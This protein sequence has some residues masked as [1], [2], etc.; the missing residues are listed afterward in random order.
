M[1]PDR[2]AVS[3][4]LSARDARSRAIDRCPPIGS[5]DALSSAQRPVGETP[6]PTTVAGLPQC[7]H[8][9]RRAAPQATRRMVAPR[10]RAV[11]RPAQRL[12]NG[13]HGSG[14][15]CSVDPGPRGRFR[16]RWGVPPGPS[17]V[18]CDRLVLPTRSA[19]R[20]AVR[21]SRD[22]RR[23]DSGYGGGVACLLVLGDL[24]QRSDARRCSYGLSRCFRRAGRPLMATR[25]GQAGL[26]NER[27]GAALRY[28]RSAAVTGR[29]IARPRRTPT[30]RVGVVR[31][32]SFGGG[33]AAATLRVPRARGTILPARTDSPDRAHHGSDGAYLRAGSG[34]SR[35]W[36]QN[37][38]DRSVWSD[39]G[40]RDLGLADVHRCARHGSGSWPRFSRLL[41]DE[42]LELV[43]HG[44]AGDPQRVGLVIAEPQK[45]AKIEVDRRE[46]IAHSPYLEVRASCLCVQA[47]R[48]NPSEPRLE[49]CCEGFGIPPHRLADHAPAAPEPSGG[50]G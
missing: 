20:R 38:I 26:F 15:A 9:S 42:V 49:C 34:C 31:A 21:C 6:H 23:V 37:E 7:A 40:E 32:T 2:S 43:E 24:I 12:R 16:I 1:V 47:V 29:R 30:D 36:C 44:V 22:G 4:G 8:G 27:R 11:G 17:R 28:H 35:D 5:S 46:L 10:C 50:S 19:C 25:G 39:E 13:R 41:D 45:L 48:K 18:Q 14:R 3:L 33:V